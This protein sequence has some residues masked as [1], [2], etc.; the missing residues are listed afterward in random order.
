M[1]RSSLE[2]GRQEIDGKE[3][4]EEKKGARAWRNFFYYHHIQRRLFMLSPSVAI[5]HHCHKPAMCYSYVVRPGCGA[6]F[7]PRHSRSSK[8]RYRQ[9]TLL[10]GGKVEIQRR[11]VQEPEKIEPA[12]AQHNTTHNTH[13]NTHFFVCVWGRTTHHTAAAYF[14]YHIWHI[15]NFIGYLRFGCERPL[16]ERPSISIYETIFPT[17]GAGWNSEQR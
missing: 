4:K 9:F 3:K 15:K 7:S 11:E 1:T 8:L 6:A 12:N 14:A 16:D 5:N 17:G 2:R 13:D 10:H